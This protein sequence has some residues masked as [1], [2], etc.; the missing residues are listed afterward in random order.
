MEHEPISVKLS[1]LPD[2]PIYNVK[3]VCVRTGISGAVLRAWERRYGVPSPN[4][5]A[6]GYRLYSERDMVILHW[7][8]QATAKG[9]NISQAVQELNVLIAQNE[10]LNIALPLH[11]TGHPTTAPRS[12]STLAAELAEAYGMLSEGQ[13]DTLLAEALALYTH[14]TVMLSI[15]RQ[16]L[17]ILRSEIRQQITAPTVE[18]F[19]INHMCHRLARTLQLTPIRVPTR[20]VRLIGFADDDSEL[21]LLMLTLLLRRAGHNAI[22]VVADFDTELLRTEVHALRTNIIL[23]YVNYPENA[24]KLHDILIAENE[25]GGLLMPMLYAGRALGFQPELRDNISLE[26]I[27]DDLRQIYRAMLARLRQVDTLEPDKV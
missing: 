5:S 25:Q 10:A 1:E 12:P 19:A 20:S 6:Q 26:Y 13:C 27:G 3:A 7:L 9:I 8:S 21:D 4:R 18:K 24:R 23:F 14:E 11:D 15:L 17:L 16:A 22:Y 2:Q